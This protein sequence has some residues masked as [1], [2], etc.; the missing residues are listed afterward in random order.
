M[1]D[2]L[3]QELKES[4][5]GKKQFQQVSAVQSILSHD[6]VNPHTLNYDKSM[7]SP[8]TIPHRRPVDNHMIRSRSPFSLQVDEMI[9]P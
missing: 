4:R 7:V 9:V 6:P 8:P 1:Q 2:D 5:F 3:A